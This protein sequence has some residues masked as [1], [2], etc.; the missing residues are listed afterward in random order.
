MSAVETKPLWSKWIPLKFVPSPDSNPN[1]YLN[2]S[3]MSDG[4]IIT[5]EFD[6]PLDYAFPSSH[7]MNDHQPTSENTNLPSTLA[8]HDPSPR[9]PNKLRKPPRPKPTNLTISQAFPPLL[10]VLSNPETTDATSSGVLNIPSGDDLTSYAVP[11]PPSPTPSATTVS[12][13]SHAPLLHSSPSPSGVVHRQSATPTRKL[14][15]RRR[16]ASTIRSNYV[17]LSNTAGTSSSSP[18]NRSVYPP[19]PQPLQSTSTD[20]Y[21]HDPNVHTRPDSYHAAT[22]TTSSSNGSQ[23][24]QPLLRSD[25]SQRRR[26]S[27]PIIYSLYRGRTNGRSNRSRSPDRQRSRR[28]VSESRYRDVEMGARVKNAEMRQEL[29]PPVRATSPFRVNIVSSLALPLTSSNISHDSQH[30]RNGMN[31]VVIFMSVRHPL[32]VALNP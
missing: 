24:L 19:S 21:L 10:H 4:L 22:S 15:K 11:L 2:D 17:K 8:F 1:V 31:D 32:Q 7:Y 30:I 3:S 20:D 9:R 13:C 29:L 6:F 28:S 14:T 23:P 25:P 16:T 18:A 5:P 12:V 26:D 27:M